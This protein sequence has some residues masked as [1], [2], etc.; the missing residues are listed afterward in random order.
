MTASMLEIQ[1]IACV[2]AVACSL[3][4]VFLVLRHMAMMSDAI[5]HSVLFGIV[6][7]FLATGDL[8]SPWLFVAAAATGVL[9]VTLVEMLNATRLVKQDAAI[10]LVFPA[11]FSVAVILISRLAGNVHLDTDAVLLGELAFAPFDRTLVFGADL[12]RGLVKMG[13]IL[14]ANAALIAVFYKELKLC[15]FDP[16]LAGSLGFAPA[17]VHYGL[18]AAVSVTAVGA[19]DVVGSILVVALMIG[20]AATAYLLT[21]RLSR[22]LAWSALLGIAGA[23]GGYWLSYLLDAS[24]AGCIAT[25]IGFEF[26][27]AHLFAPDRGMVAAWRRRARQRRDFA[28]AMLAIHLLN[29]EDTPEAGRENRVENLNEH[30]RWS[31]RFASEVVAIAVRRGT[32][33]RDGGRLALTDHGRGLAREAMS[34]T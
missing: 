28:E 25:V 1:V 5:S 12:P 4:G 14:A 15:T 18:M 29:H 24:I 16:L 17:A 30:L 23:L 19:F 7:A 20:P 26:G 22:M 27:A 9:T 8:S 3:V 13:V 2:T 21:S 11:L 34:I 33:T 10:G 31:P 32:V 6:L